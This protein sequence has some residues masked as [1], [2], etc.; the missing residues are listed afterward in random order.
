MGLDMYLKAS[1]YIS[2]YSH[3]K[4]EEKATLEG[5]I[6]AVGIT[7]SLLSSDSPS[8]TVCVNVMYWRKA[9]AI[10][11]WFV[12]NC[13]D[14]ND[15]CQEAYVE[16][17]SLE[18][19]QKLCEEAVAQKN[20]KALPPTQGFFFGSSDADEYYWEDLKK[21]AEELKKILSDESLKGCDFYYRSSW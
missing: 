13:Q 8:A 4:P 6:K 17:S 15:N 18:E 3:S 20:S 7:P 5:V 16:R 2:G 12:E 11:G 9:N 21:T 1:K 19:L 14:G 10:H